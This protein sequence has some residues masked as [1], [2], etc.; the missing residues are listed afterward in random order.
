MTSCRSAG[1]T[2][3]GAWKEHSRNNSGDKVLDINASLAAFELTATRPQESPKMKLNVREPSV[4]VDDA[5]GDQQH[6]TGAP[7]TGVNERAAVA[8]PLVNQFAGSAGAAGAVAVGGSSSS[9]SRHM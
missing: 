9:S 1:R 6:A 7:A 8:R 3:R 4:F 2:G 5:R